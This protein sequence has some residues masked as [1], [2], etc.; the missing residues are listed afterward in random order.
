MIVFPNC[1]INLGLH[2]LHKRQDG[3][4]DLESVFFPLPIHDALEFILSPD[5]NSPAFTISGLAIDINPSQNIVYKAFE[6]LKADFPFITPVHIHLHKNIPMG[7]GLGGGSSDGAYALLLL[8]KIFKLGIDQQKLVDYAAQLGSD[9]PFFILNQPCYVTGRG[10]KMERVEL[11]LSGFS[12]VIIYPGIHIP[13]KWAFAQVKPA[14]PR[15]SL[16]SLI[17]FPVE[18]WKNELKNDFEAPVF[19]HY[20][21]IKVIRDELY[22]K[23]AVYASMSGSGSSVYGIFKKSAIPV[24]NFPSEYFIKSI[25]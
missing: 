20:P 2:I 14:L 18:E 19:Q 23:G 25:Q 22:E 10:E 16:R 4:H 3:F 15:T 24:F 17:T 12:I 8:N 1:K 13:T 21:L 9:C 11:D 5:K 6:L 7:A